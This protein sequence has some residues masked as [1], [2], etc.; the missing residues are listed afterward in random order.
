[1]KDYT[2]LLW[3]DLDT[4]SWLDRAALLFS[5]GELLRTLPR[6]LLFFLPERRDDVLPPQ[7]DRA[8]D[9]LVRD[10]VDLHR[11][12]LNVFFYTLRR[13]DFMPVF[14]QELRDARTRP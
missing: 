10:V 14:A 1:M 9:L 12:T 7:L 13:D 8:H 3:L 5:L 4:I 11:F 6:R 2:N